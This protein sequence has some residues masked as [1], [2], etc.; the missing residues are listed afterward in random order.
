MKHSGQSLRPVVFFLLGLLL[1]PALLAEA[2]G[3]GTPRL[4]NEPAGPY[5]LSVWTSPDPAR[6]GE[7][8]HLTVGVTEPGTGQEAGAPVLGAAVALI[9]SPV[10]GAAEPVTAAAADAAN[11]LLYE[12]DVTL[13]EPGRWAVQ[14]DVEGS[15]GRGS[16]SFELDVEE[17]GSVP[18]LLWASGGVLVLGALF[19]LARRR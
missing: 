1:L 16:A 11:K 3:G 10:R 7:P 18:W 6:A 8:L 17:R 13:P 12:A 15:A 14:A 2:H 5:W 19:L 9:L 4:E